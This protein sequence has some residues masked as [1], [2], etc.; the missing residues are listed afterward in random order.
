MPVSLQGDGYLTVPLNGDD[1][2]TSR[3]TLSMNVNPG[4]EDGPIVIV[5]TEESVCR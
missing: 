1:T 3:M 5:Q 2:K 4:G